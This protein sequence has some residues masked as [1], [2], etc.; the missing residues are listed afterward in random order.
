MA[1][2]DLEVLQVQSNCQQYID[3]ILARLRFGYKDQVDLTLNVSLTPFKERFQDTV[4]G[5]TATLEVVVPV[6]LNECVA[7]FAELVHSDTAY[8]PNRDVSYNS[9][10]VGTRLAFPSWQIP[11]E[12]NAYRIVGSVTFST[13]RALTDDA[14]PYDVP[15]FVFMQDADTP[16]YIREIEFDGSA[17]KIGES[18]TINFDFTIGLQD[19]PPDNNDMSFTF[20]YSSGG[21]Y[22]GTTIPATAY[23]DAIYLTG[24]EL[25]IYAS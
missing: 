6:S 5:M 3:D 23:T 7:P 20:G 17:A 8:Q 2:N 13:N 18:Q 16:R 4:A 24:G 9:T 21:N 1:K 12:Y 22:P 15:F 11:E 25:K 19:L 10:S 14:S